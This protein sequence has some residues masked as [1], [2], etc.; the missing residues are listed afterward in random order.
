LGGVYNTSV[1]KIWPAW[2]GALFLGLLNIGL[3][4]YQRPWSTY[5]GLRLWGYSILDAMGLHYFGVLPS[6]FQDSTS[7][8]DIGLLLGAFAGAH[9]ALSL[10]HI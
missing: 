6:P 5:S 9:L 8:I 4:Y 10:I 3:T 2:M 7:V 1:L